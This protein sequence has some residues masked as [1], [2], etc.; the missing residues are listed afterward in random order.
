MVRLESLTTAVRRG[1]LT[2][3]MRL[4]AGHRPMFGRRRSSAL[5]AGTA[6]L[7]DELSREGTRGL[8]WVRVKCFVI[9][10]E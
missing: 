10:H 8:R 1:R 9:Y 6:N 4:R 5:P 2:S 3:W 7:W